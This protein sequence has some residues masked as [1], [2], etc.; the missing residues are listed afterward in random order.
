MTIA[1]AHLAGPGNVAHTEANL[2]L[3]HDDA[4]DLGVHAR[5]PSVHADVGVVHVDLSHMHVS[6]VCSMVLERSTACSC[7]L[8]ASPFDV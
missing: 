4:G 5:E 6:K 1:A 8:S 3:L 2:G 7:P